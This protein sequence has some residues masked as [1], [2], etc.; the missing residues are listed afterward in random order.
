MN[1]RKTVVSL[2]AAAALSMSIAAPVA[3]AE[4]SQ[5]SRDYHA[6]AEEDGVLTPAHLWSNMTFGAVG[7]TASSGGQLSQSNILEIEDTRAGSPGWIVQVST[8][9]MI[10]ENPAHFIEAEN[11]TVKRNTANGLSGWRNACQFSG[12]EANPS[13]PFQI[14]NMLVTT[15]SSQPLTSGVNVISG[16]AG[17]GCGKVM[18]N[19]TFTLTVPAGQNPDTYNGNV[20]VT[21]MPNE[22]Q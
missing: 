12:L 19:T 6:T 10:G 20:I 21:T 14:T 11:L 2:F 13:N 22:P 18:A 5:S 7:V 1:L 4:D 9:G 17:R 3:F 8:S 15:D 16:E